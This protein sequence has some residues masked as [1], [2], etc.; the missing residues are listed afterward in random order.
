MLLGDNTTE[1]RSYSGRP[2]SGVLGFG[3]QLDSLFCTHMLDDN[4]SSVGSSAK[5]DIRRTSREV[6][7][8]V[9]GVTVMTSTKCKQ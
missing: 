1:G 2:G 7:L 3:F 9:R 5:V 8:G 4:I 6:I